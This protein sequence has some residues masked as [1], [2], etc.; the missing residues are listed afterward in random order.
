MSVSF[1]TPGQ[2][3]LNRSLCSVLPEVIEWRMKRNR[4]KH[5]EIVKNNACVQSE[6]GE[7]RLNGKGCADVREREK[8][9]GLTV[10]LKHSSP[11]WSAH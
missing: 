9:V 2:R 4:F 1:F 11:G 3:N 10:E 7:Q 6:T 5:T 8:E